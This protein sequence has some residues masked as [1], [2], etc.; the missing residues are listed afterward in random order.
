MGKNRQRAPACF[1]AWINGPQVRSEQA[2]TALGFM[3]CGNPELP[4]TVEQRRFKTWHVLYDDGTH[5]G[6]NSRWAGKGRVKVISRPGAKNRRDARDCR[7]AAGCG[8]AQ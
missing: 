4:Q 3:D 2:R 1:G 7:P 8:S 5:N 6:F